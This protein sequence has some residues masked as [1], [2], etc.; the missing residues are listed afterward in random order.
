MLFFVLSAF[1]FSF[2]FSCLGDFCFTFSLLQKQKCSLQTELFSN[3]P[4]HDD[5]NIRNHIP[6][7][8]FPIGSLYRV[9][10]ILPGQF[11]FLYKFI[12]SFLMG[13][14][15]TSLYSITTIFQSYFFLF[16]VIFFSSNQFYRLLINL[17]VI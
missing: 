12:I 4:L 14:W 15:F 3:F 6:H 5:C 9:I 2:F 8:F 11:S 7:L 10:I 17:F 13:S 16:C 1:F